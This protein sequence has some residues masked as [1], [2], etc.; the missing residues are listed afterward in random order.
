[1][2]SLSGITYD[3]QGWLT[4]SFNESFLK[5]CQPV[6]FFN[7]LTLLLHWL[8]RCRLQYNLRDPTD[9]RTWITERAMM[10]MRSR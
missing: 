6:F 4:V 1:M 3:L 8:E 9:G 10:S 5:R 2:D 7:V